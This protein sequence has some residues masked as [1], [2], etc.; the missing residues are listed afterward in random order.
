MK[1]E[2]LIASDQAKETGDFTNYWNVTVDYIKTIK[3]LFKNTIKWAQSERAWLITHQSPPYSQ[4]TR[5]HKLIDNLNLWDARFNGFNKM[6]EENIKEDLP[7]IILINHFL[8]ML[9]NNITRMKTYFDHPYLAQ[10]LKITTLLSN[11]TLFQNNMQ[12]TLNE[13]I[14][15][16]NLQPTITQ[17]PGF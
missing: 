3:E 16:R 14:T 11:L 9:K 6:H 2:L 15:E 5:F 4:R 17:F 8:Y 12:S 13:I 7:K 10:P 1:T